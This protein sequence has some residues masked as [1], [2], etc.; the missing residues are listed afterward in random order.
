MDMR[1]E[2]AIDIYIK[3][4]TAKDTKKTIRWKT[5]SLNSIIRYFRNI[6]RLEYTSEINLSIILDYITYE[7]S[8]VE[9][10]TVNK[11]IRLLKHLFKFND[12]PFDWNKVSILTVT[13]KTIDMLSDTEIQVLLKYINNLDHSDLSTNNLTYK[14]IYFF[15]LDAGS[16]IDETLSIKKENIDFTNNSI[17][18]MEDI[19]GDK[20]RYVFF[21][22]FSKP[23]IEILCKESKSEYL[24]YNFIKNRKF[25]YDNDI[26]YMYKVMRKHTGYKRLTAHRCRH[27]FASISI[28]NGM[29]ILSLQKILGH[30]SLKSTYVYLH[31]NIKR[32]K[33]EYDQFSPFKGETMNQIIYGD[34]NVKKKETN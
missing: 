21:S 7:K 1:I 33:K 34:I 11:K 2:D 13:R 22:D 12:I 5:L 32:A 18:L 27:T 17:K 6:R 8:R 31:S 19:K 24:F 25:D 20:W 16:R 14:A 9:N 4:S 29:N 15:L 30:D 26:Q 3:S 10:V 23:Y 28:E